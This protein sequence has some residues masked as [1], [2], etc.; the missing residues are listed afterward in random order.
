MRSLIMRSETDEV[1]LAQE[2]GVIMKGI[3]L[4][5]ELEG[6]FGEE[7]GGT[8]VLTNRRLI[9]VSSNDKEDELPV[10]DILPGLKMDVLYSEVEELNS[11]P[12]DPG[13]LFISISSISSV[14][15][16]RMELT[17]PSLE[18]KWREGSEERGRV[19]VEA[20]TGR[21]RRR[22]LNDWAPVIERLKTGDQKLISVPKAP[23]VEA[24][25]GKI[26]GIMS[27]MQW[28][29]VLGI[30]EE[31]EER[32]K[33]EVGPD[34]VQAACDKLCSQGLLVRKPEPGDVFYRKR[35]P[36]GDDDLS[37]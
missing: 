1:M 32:F 24:L 9:F 25:E 5:K 31:V 7:L 18:V 26:M 36:L 8:L 19:F 16:Y 27:D 30:E 21:S 22:N 29:G 2:Q 12:T 14:H 34:E 33:T 20:V 4:E 13:N 3:G 28:K 23:G 15:G 37:D 35:S 17:R 11:I 10:P 6:G